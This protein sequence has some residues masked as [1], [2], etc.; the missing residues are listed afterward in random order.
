MFD[1]LGYFFH[2]GQMPTRH[3]SVENAALATQTCGAVAARPKT[4][5]AFEVALIPKSGP[6]AKGP[7]TQR[8]D[9]Q[10]KLRQGLYNRRMFEPVQSADGE[11]WHDAD[12]YKP[13]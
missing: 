1:V 5:R 4:K 8:Q 12:A 13:Q 3:V 11:E 10:R 2:L 6:S 9:R 7:T